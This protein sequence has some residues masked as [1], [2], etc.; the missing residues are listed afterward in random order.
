MNVLIAPDKFKGGATAMEVAQAIQ[1]GIHLV[2]QSVET[3]LCPMADG[4]EGTSEMLVHY[5]KGKFQSAK[6]HDPLG[7]MIQAAYGI[8]GDGKT[9][10]IDMSA[11]SGLAL[12][13]PS[14]RNV[15]LTSTLGTG[16]LILAA[17]A[18]GVKSI[19]LGIGGSATN[20][21]GMGMAHAL[22]Y[23]FL[24][25]N[26]QVL[27][28][29]GKNLIHVNHISYEETEP[30][31]SNTKFIIACDVTNPFYGPNGAA[32]VYAPQK[33]AHENELPVLDKGLQRLAAV[34]A[35]DLEVDIQGV[36]G[37][38]AAG[39]LG[40][41]SLAFLQGELRSGIDIVMAMMDFDEKLKRSDLVL[42]GEG[43][44]DAQTAYGKVIKGICLQAQKY[45]VP[46]VGIC[47]S[48]AESYEL[49]Q[50]IGLTH[51]F[52]IINQPMSLETAIK[53]TTSLLTS[54]TARFFSFYKQV[55]DN[56]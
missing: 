1:K 6:V 31:L 32:Y 47:G 41:G 48:L 13:N 50:Q 14:E 33:G 17:L 39:G 40:G 19:Y 52:S 4:G 18:Q 11:A 42:T 34:I 25:E 56:M 30:F 29:S 44:I 24:D 51:S 27:Q 46:V 36:P 21:G 53:N 10:F 45:N 7:R 2:D 38:G 15:M 35:K 37:S 54:S 49:I 23:R 12:L 20:D 8:S 22:G 9:A 5:T 55:I 43:K 3:T 28:P 26:K 16:E